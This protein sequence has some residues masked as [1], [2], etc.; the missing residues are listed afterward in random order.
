MEEI[1]SKNN[2]DPVHHRLSG[3]FHL[4]YL[5]NRHMDAPEA[6]P[7]VM[8]ANKSWASSTS[9]ASLLMDSTCGCNQ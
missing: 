5:S 4:K 8:Y 6:R 3:L 1:K 9:K 7:V 2:A